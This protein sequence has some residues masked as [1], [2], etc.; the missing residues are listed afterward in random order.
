[1]K[2]PILIAIAFR[3]KTKKLKPLVIPEEVR[4]VAKEKYGIII[5]D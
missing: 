2:H 1:M 3:R 5:R 4:K